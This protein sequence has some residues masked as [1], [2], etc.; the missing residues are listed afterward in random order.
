MGH[1]FEKDE[2]FKMFELHLDFGF[3]FEAIFGLWL[4]FDGVKKSGLELDRT[5]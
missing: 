4:D 3:I 1:F 2:F 5:I